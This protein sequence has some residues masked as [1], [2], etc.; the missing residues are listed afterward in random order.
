MRHVKS[1]IFWTVLGGTL[2]VKN[3][4]SL[5][6]AVQLMMDASMIGHQAGIE[7]ESQQKPQAICSYR[8]KMT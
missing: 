3:A 2:K 6:Q 4:P 5:L 8:Y 7:G 1:S